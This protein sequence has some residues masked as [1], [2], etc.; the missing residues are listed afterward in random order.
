ME[1]K[2][3]MGVQSCYNILSKM[4]GFKGKIMPRKE[5]GWNSPYTGLTHKFYPKFNKLTTVL[6]K[7]FPKKMGESTS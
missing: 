3:G 7:F 1:G 4:S 2:E 6:H 5:T